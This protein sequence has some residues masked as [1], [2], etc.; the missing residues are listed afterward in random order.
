MPTIR[1]TATATPRSSASGQF[2]SSRVTPAV[3]A[4]VTAFANL[5]LQEAQAIVPVDTGTLRDSGSVVVQDTPKTVVGHVVFSAPY[6]AYV[7]YGTGRRGAESAGAGPYPY[8]LSWPGMSARPYLRPA[9]DTA[10]QAGMELFNSQI[11]AA[12]RV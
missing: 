5:V 4:A 8:T 11:A 3:R 12:M 10:R 9:L 1:A 6:A 7:E 2:I